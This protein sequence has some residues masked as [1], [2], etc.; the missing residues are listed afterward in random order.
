MEVKETSAL[1]RD[2]SKAVLLCR[3]D[4]R[5][6][7]QLTREN[8]DLALFISSTTLAMVMMIWCNYNEELLYTVSVSDEAPVGLL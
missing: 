5:L 7:P 6:S 4:Q 8:E 3:V 2:I 1:I